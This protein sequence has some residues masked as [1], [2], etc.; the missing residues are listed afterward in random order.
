MH[1][2]AALG[3]CAL[4][5]VPRGGTAGHVQGGQGEVNLFAVPAYALAASLDVCPLETSPRSLAT[6]DTEALQEL[7]RGKKPKFKQAVTATDSMCLV[8]PRTHLQKQILFKIKCSYHEGIRN[9]LWEL[10]QKKK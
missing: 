1:V 4:Q 2:P 3:T 9:A 8:H 6:G 10:S 7:P 5:Q